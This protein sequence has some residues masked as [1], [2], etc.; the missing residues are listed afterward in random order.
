MRMVRGASRVNLRA[1]GAC[2][3]S[4]LRSE[5]SKPVSWRGQNAKINKIHCSS[6]STKS[7]SPV[8]CRSMGHQLL[9]EAEKEPKAWWPMAP[10]PGRGLV[11]CEMKAGAVK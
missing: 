10:T 8:H 2:E 3:A 6:V 5:P 7:Y 11:V 4:L 1:V 9:L